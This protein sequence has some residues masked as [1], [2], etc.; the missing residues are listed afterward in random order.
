MTGL[1]AIDPGY[2]AHGKGCACARF[3][4]GRLVAVWYA[5]AT[6]VTLSFARVSRVVWECPELRPRG[7]G[8]DPATL[9]RLAVEGAELAGRYAGVHGATITRMTPHDWKG[10]TP[11]PMHHARLWSVLDATERAVL[12]GERTWRAIEAARKKGALSRWPPGRTFYGASYTDHNLL[13]AA[14]LGCVALGRMA[15]G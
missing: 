9:M 15:K 2:A 6:D 3:F 12:G 4:E 13:D 14:A 1:L 10:T 8:A 7:G 5:R 11:K